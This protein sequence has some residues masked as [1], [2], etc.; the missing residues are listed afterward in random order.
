MRTKAEYI[1]GLRK[2]YNNLYF[3]GEKIDRL[4]PF[5]EPAIN[6]MGLTFDAAWDPEL[7]DLCTATSHLTGETI[8][9]FNHIHQNTEDLHKKQDMTR[10]LCN[11]VT[12]HSEMY[13]YRCCQRD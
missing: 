4:H 7:K 3:N 5:Q 12:V 13:G 1:E 9:R 11:K 8:N 6:V 10:A 2:K